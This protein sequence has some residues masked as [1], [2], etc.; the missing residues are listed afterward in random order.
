[1]YQAPNKL[2]SRG[3]IRGIL[4]DRSNLIAWRFRAHAARDHHPVN[5]GVLSCKVCTDYAG[6]M[7]SLEDM[8]RYFGGRK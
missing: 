6:Q 1:M 3:E 4:R 7:N 2:F 5:V 8:I